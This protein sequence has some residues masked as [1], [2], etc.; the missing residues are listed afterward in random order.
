MSMLD[1]TRV[2]ADPGPL[3]SR[4]AIGDESMEQMRRDIDHLKACFEQLI[5]IVGNQSDGDEEVTLL[6]DRMSLF[7]RRMQRAEDGVADLSWVFRR[8]AGDK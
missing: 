2:A 6:N 5:D 1:E 3:P 4:R 8:R 7:E